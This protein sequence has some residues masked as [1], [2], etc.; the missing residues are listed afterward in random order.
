M[1]KFLY[2]RKAIHGDSTEQHLL[3]VTEM[4]QR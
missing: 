1:P 4:I 2:E 3:P